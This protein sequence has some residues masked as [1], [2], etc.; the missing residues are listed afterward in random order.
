MEGRYRR[1]RRGCQL[2]EDFGREGNY[3]KGILKL[4]PH[5]SP[6]GRR[7]PKIPHRKRKCWTR[8]KEKG[9]EGDVRS[10]GGGQKGEGW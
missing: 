4:I 5:E 2:R 8:H 10:A 1:W 3:G 9:T 7:E 6:E